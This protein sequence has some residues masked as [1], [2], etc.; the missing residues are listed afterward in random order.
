M[1][2]L[3]NLTKRYANN[4]I[5]FSNRNISIENNE[6]VSIVGPSGI[7]K[8]TLLNIIGLLD[9]EFEGKYIFNGKR[10]DTFH[11][12]RKSK[13]RNEQFGFIFQSYNLLDDLNVY[14]NILL[15]IMY[16]KEKLSQKLREHIDFLMNHLQIQNLFGVE[17]RNLSGGEKQRIA[18]ARALLFSPEFI[19]ADEPTG[20]LDN[21]NETI[22]LGLFEQLKKDG[23]TIILV[24]HNQRAAEYADRIIDLG[25]G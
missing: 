14:E 23:K 25:K 21:E 8:S 11:D 20:N 16:S 19:L 4:K 22:V 7:G 10:I 18:I 24:T 2:E 13:I 1:I 12:R 9:D 6:F 3:V 17:V 15:P 5:I